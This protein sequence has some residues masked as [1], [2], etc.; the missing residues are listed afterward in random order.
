MTRN[1]YEQ[2]V[3]IF[4]HLPRTAGTTLSRF[5]RSK[6]APDAIF[7]AYL[8]AG[9]TLSDQLSALR[10]LPPEARERIRLVLAGHAEF[11]QHEALSP[12]AEYVT[13]LRD[14]VDRVVSSYRFLQ[15]HP[16]DP[17]HAQ[18]VGERMS[19]ATFVKSDAAKGINNWQARCL[20]GV[21]WSA[22]EWGPEVLDRAKRNVERHFAV[23]G[24]TERFPETIALLG[25]LYGWR[26]LYYATLNISS[27][28]ASCTDEDR[29]LILER[30]DL[31]QKLYEFAITKFNEQLA[32]FSNIDADLGRL[33]RQNRVYDPFYRTYRRMRQIKRRLARS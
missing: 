4:L 18:V 22:S 30:N 9:E 25:R 29:Q 23:V 21:P 5:L 16:N 31:D 19:L 7:S 6:F 28:R 12:G 24:L 8:D 11:G 14:P 3:L 17:L 10:G 26:R 1:E 32:R 27:S 33:R 2:R 13:V 15:D 20:A